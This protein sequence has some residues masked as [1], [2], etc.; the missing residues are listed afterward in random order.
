MLDTVHIIM[1]HHKQD[2][3]DT[4]VITMICATEELAEKKLAWLEENKPNKN[5]EYWIEEYDLETP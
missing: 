3:P 5:F 4:N 2:Y 1:R